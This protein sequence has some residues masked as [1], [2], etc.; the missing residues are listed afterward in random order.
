MCELL[1]QFAYFFIPLHQHWFS[2]VSDS[3]EIKRES[4]VN[5]EQ[6]PLL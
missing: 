3:T 2:G 1:M 6:F 5:P 4:G